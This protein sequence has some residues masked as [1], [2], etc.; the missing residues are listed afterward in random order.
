MPGWSGAGLRRVGAQAGVDRKTARHYVNAAVAAGLDRDGGVEQLTD[1]LIG[2]VVAAV[3]P[4]RPQGHGAGWEALERQHEQIVEWVG[5]DLT[6]VKI[7]DLLARRGVLVAQRTLHRYCVERTDYRGRAR[8][9][10]AGGRR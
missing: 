3:R 6:V 7:G 1:E 10:G 9:D 4:E 8:G 5:K 2:Q